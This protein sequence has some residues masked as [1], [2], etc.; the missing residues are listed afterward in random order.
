MLLLLTPLLH[1][2]LLDGQLVHSPLESTSLLIYIQHGLRCVHIYSLYVSPF[3]WD[4][5][6]QLLCDGCMICVVIS[7]EVGDIG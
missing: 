4:L 3:V 2:Q 7:L 6:V 5:S 1:T